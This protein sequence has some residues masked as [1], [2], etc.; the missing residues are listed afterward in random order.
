MT[1]E[2]KVAR[3]IYDASVAKARSE[4]AHVADWENIPRYWREVH[5]NSARAAISAMQDEQQQGALW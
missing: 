3:A 4:S 2:E 1:L 5:L